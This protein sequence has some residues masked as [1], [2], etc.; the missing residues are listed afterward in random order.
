MALCY[1][2][3]KPVQHHA[4]EPVT[5][6]TRGVT[7]ESPTSPRTRGASEQPL[8]NSLSRDLL[9]NGSKEITGQ[10]LLLHHLQTSTMDGPTSGNTF[11]RL[12]EVVTSKKYQLSLP[13]STKSQPQ[14]CIYYIHLIAVLIQSPQAAKPNWKAH[15]E[16]V[17]LRKWQK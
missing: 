17:P 7:A 9:N 11:L 16:A 15:S 1:P 3:C 8:T 10:T 6:L 12:Q 5:Y 13:E 14:Q 2:R 4:T